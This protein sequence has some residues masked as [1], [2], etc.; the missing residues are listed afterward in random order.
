[1][2]SFSKRKGSKPWQSS[3]ERERE[4]ERKRERNPT[5]ILCQDPWRETLGRRWLSRWVLWYFWHFFKNWILSENIQIASMKLWYLDL[6]YIMVF[7]SMFLLCLDLEK[8]RLI[9]IHLTWSRAKEQSN[10]RFPTNPSLAFYL[11]WVLTFTICFWSTTKCL[12]LKNFL[13]FI[14]V[15]NTFPEKIKI[16]PQKHLGIY[17]GFYSPFIIW[18]L[19][20]Q[21]VDVCMTHFSHWWNNFPISRGKKS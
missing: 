15:C 1:M 17:V 14:Y 7:K 11:S 20:P 6:Y 5:I 19:E 9:F 10:S 18:Y 2:S 3:R 16:D 12:S 21:I 13:L 8:F 4:R